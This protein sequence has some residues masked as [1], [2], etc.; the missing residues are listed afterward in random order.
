MTKKNISKVSPE[1]RTKLC[2]GCR[3]WKLLTLEFF[4]KKYKYGL[5]SRCKICRK[6]IMKIRYHLIQKE[7]KLRNVDTTKERERY[8]KRLRNGKVKESNKR[9]VE[10]YPYKVRA[11]AITVN[12]IRKGI[13]KKEPCEVCGNEKVDTHHPDYKKPMLVKW[14]CRKH[15]MELHR[16]LNTQK[17]LKMLPRKKRLFK[18]PTK[19]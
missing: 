11:R 1:I 18:L 3:E 12:A 8:L 16:N 5:E 19:K 7:N 2:S 4:Y 6:T 15:H 17:I 10:K 13:L 14:L 9:T